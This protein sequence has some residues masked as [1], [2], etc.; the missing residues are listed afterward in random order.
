MGGLIAGLT[1]GLISSGTKLAGAV[2]S[3]GLFMKVIARVVHSGVEIFVK[4]T[5]TTAD[6]TW[7]EPILVKLKEHF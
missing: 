2:M 7:A 5:K 3:E 6:D 4:S 1:A